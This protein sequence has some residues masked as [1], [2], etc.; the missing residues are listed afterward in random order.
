MD[1]KD[2]L[3]NQVL[4]HSEPESN[5]KRALLLT[6]ERYRDLVENANSIILQMDRQGRITFWNKFAATFFGYGKEE[7]IGK[8]VL[9]TIVPYSET[10][11][12]NLRLLMEDICAHPE[13]YTN[14][15]N[16]NTK[17]N[18][19][20]VWIVWTNRPVMDPDNRLEGVLCI[21]ND[22]TERMLME[23]RLKQAKDELELRVKVRTAE[24]SRANEELLRHLDQRRQAEETIREAERFLYSI[25]SSI[26]D[27]ISILDKDMKI[28]QVNQTMENWY[29]HAGGLI[30]KTCY[31]AYHGQS[32]PCENCPVR[33]TLE[34]GGSYHE[35]IPW[36]AS[37]RSIKGWFYLYSSPLIDIKT[38]RMKGVIEY[39][40]DI[41]KEKLF[42][43][44]LTK[45]N[46]CFLEFGADSLDNINRI[47][48]LCGQLLGADCA[49][50]SRIDKGTI[51]TIGQWNTPTDFPDKDNAEGHICNDVAKLNKEEA[52]VVRDLA[53]SQYAQSDPNVVKYGLQTYIG[54]PVRLGDV[55]IGSLCAVYTRDY[56]L[57]EEDK[58][59]IGILASAIAIEEKRHISEQALQYRFEFE[60]LITS[61]STSFINLS[62]EEIDMAIADALKVIG[63]FVKADRS[64]IFLFNLDGQKFNNAY[65][66]CACGIEPQIHRLQGI[67]IK[68]FPWIIQ[69]MNNREVAVV[70][71]TL[72]LP[73]E[74]RNEKE[75]FE[76]EGI[77]SLINVP[78]FSGRE[79]LGFLGFDTVH[80]ETFWSQDVI[81]LM[82]IAGEIFAHAFERKR[83]RQK[84]EQ[85]NKEL[86]QSNK[87]LKQLALR[88]SQ[89][90]LYNHHYL[91]E[92]IEAEFHRSYRYAHPL[93]AIMLDIDYFKSINDV[94][95]H[96][97][98]DTILQ[99]FSGQLKRM[100]RQYD[101]VVRFGGEEFVIISPG[102]DR[103]TAMVLGQRILD[104]LNLYN[105]GNK[106]HV[107][108]L[109][110][111]IGIASYPD[112]QITKGMDLIELADNILN[113]AKENGGNTVYSSLDIA[114]GK[115]V[116]FQE[117]KKET[118]ETKFLKEKIARLTRRSS[119]SLVEAVFAFAKTIE[120][121]D[122]YTGE[123]VEK[124]VHY[125]TEIARVLGLPK[126]DRER[127]HQAAILH[128]LGK[129]GI[130]EKI[131]LKKSKL[132]KKELSEIRKHPQ[133][134]VDIIRPIQFLHSIIPF[135]L[136]HHERWDGKGYPSGLKGEEIP[137]GA[138]IIAIADVY[139]ALI[140]DR[141]YRKAFSKDKVIKIIKSSAGT[142]FDPKVVG[143]LLKII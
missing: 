128:D 94:Y 132:D 8:S 92:I 28:V 121:K 37:D 15:I 125:A 4:N 73:P 62:I 127:I 14:N 99:Q 134:G 103:Q 97:F 86:T 2:S 135:I 96:Q 66:W 110:I 75:E 118:E 117:K 76:L 12:R 21:G 47:T 78:M 112:D 122:H 60:K 105:F 120:L 23:E 111:S 80:Q 143:G 49:L 19:Q 52:F 115:R 17:K 7:I 123:H 113:K 67:N 51:C 100:V 5:L 74:A 129:I 55:S 25:F 65:E 13:L 81:F 101:I 90:G 64:Y 137:M 136:Y 88:D 26:K 119:Q 68:K 53:H 29:P 22:I 1:K 131:L 95:G 40:R 84:V 6:Q 82:R 83:S 139:Q 39:V 104:A 33:K 71:R 27:G 109:K 44:R 114:N 59:I 43:E 57:R 89:T 58:G 45:I 31:K 41:T 10:G 130:S 140:S 70:E 116:V 91:T 48:N 35:V 20:R 36:R 18:G 24:L 77:K 9:G 79:L 93:S 87:V 142:Q 108:K 32:E 72:D 61:I 42:Q 124:T 69:K 54:Y 102:T 56:D 141:P 3:S 30:G 106:K 16:E 133:I 98:G 50:Y 63:E 46:E 38:G 85:L 138:R 11:G 107:I 126:E 34:T